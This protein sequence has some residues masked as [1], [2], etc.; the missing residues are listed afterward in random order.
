MLG[1]TRTPAANEARAMILEQAQDWPGAERAWSDYAST[2]L[3]EN[4]DLNEGQSRT[5]LRLVTAAARATD[6]AALESLRTKYASRLG[7]GAFADMF[8]LLA[9]EPVRG[10]SDL[11]RAQQE[12][13]LAQSLPANLK[14]LEVA[15]PGR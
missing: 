13:T 3:P 10:T 6:N 5:L 8:R 1:A 12:A 11:E 14:A 4:G 7:P 15:S 2:E 9:A